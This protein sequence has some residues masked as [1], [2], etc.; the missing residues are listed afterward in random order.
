MRYGNPNIPDALARLERAGVRRVLLFPLYPQYAAS[1]T[2][3]ALAAARR[4]AAGHPAPVSLFQVPPFYDDPGFV[5]AFRQVGRDVLRDM[6]PD[7]VLF[8]FHGLPERQ[9]LRS[10]SSGSHCLVTPDCCASVQEINR[11]CYRAQCFETARRIAA[12]V[13][14]DPG[15]W[16][17]SFQSR[18]GRTPWIRPYTD[19]VLAGLPSEGV[20]RLAVFCPAFVADCLETLEEI[21]VRGRERFRQ[22]G[23]DELRLV[24]SLNDHPAWV[25]AAVALIRKSARRN[26]APPPEVKNAVTFD[27]TV[28]P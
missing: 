14:L 5:E 25:E 22:C 19:E 13:G 24:P 12:A 27:S 17:V 9:I 10:D 21:G 26:T 4:W 18:F 6:Q 23:G 1:T 7:R 8:S 3:S 11:S 20:R 15:N 28:I 2:G 16:S